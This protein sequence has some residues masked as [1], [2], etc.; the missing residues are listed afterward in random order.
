MTIVRVCESVGGHCMA[1]NSSEAICLEHHS[2][3]MNVTARL[4]V[5]IRYLPD[6]EFDWSDCSPQRSR[7]DI[8]ID[9]L[10][11]SVEDSKIL[12]QRALDL[13]KEFIVSHFDVLSDLKQFLP[14]KPVDHPVVKSEVIPMKMLMKD[15]K[16]T[17]ESIDILIQI[18]ND[19]GFTGDHQVGLIYLIIKL[20]IHFRWL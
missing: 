16:Y 1:R 19:A 9:D 13:T 10:L 7:Q 3:M 20:K 12:Y 2:S 18:F 4:A 17:T 6:F 15:E 5:K 14:S 8:V 11:P